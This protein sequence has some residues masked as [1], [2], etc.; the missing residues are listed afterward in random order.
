MLAQTGKNVTALPE[1]K[2][3]RRNT[4]ALGY[5]GDAT[6]MEGSEEE[7]KRRLMRVKGSKEPA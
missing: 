4:N 2:T 5:V 7:L 3:G 1:T 6:R